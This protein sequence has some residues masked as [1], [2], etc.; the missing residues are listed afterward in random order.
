MSGRVNA[1]ER[2]IF[3]VL[4]RSDTLRQR[5]T[6]GIP[7]SLF[8]SPSL[9][10]TPLSLFQREGCPRWICR[11]HPVAGLGLGRAKRTMAIRSAV[12]FF[13]ALSTLGLAYAQENETAGASEK[14]G[15]DGKRVCEVLPLG[16]RSSTSKSTAWS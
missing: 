8:S 6:H 1:L 2:Q 4:T 12:A 15:R 5:R 16:R 10:F 13:A 9:P 7:G 11:N 3:S 14:R